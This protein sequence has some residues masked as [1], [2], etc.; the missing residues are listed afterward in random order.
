MNTKKIVPLDQVDDYDDGFE[1]PNS[2][3]KEKYIS[4]DDNSPDFPNQQTLKFI[5][6]VK[7]LPLNM[8]RLLSHNR[9]I[10]LDS[11]DND[12]PISKKAIAKISYY[13]FQGLVNEPSNIQKEQEL[14]AEDAENKET[15]EEEHERLMDTPHTEHNQF[16]YITK[17]PVFDL[18]KVY[19]DQYPLLTLRKQLLFIKR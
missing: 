13:Y 8:M 12:S 6:R 14:E 4:P 5:E 3:L 1:L 15:I 10:T 9:T 16:V 17:R 2:P 11:E 18:L 7:T 19:T